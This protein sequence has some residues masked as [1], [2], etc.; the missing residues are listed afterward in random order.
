MLKPRDAFVEHQKVY[1]TVPCNIC[2]RL[3]K[4]WCC[5]AC[6]RVISIVLDE[7]ERL[8]LVKEFLNA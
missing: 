1:T 5:E 6:R 4:T 8:Q 7:P 2:G 3:S